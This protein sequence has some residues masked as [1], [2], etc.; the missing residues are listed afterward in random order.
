MRGQFR[1]TLAVPAT[2]ERLAPLARRIIEGQTNHYD[3][4]MAII[5]H[6]ESTCKYTLMEEPTP[7]GTD[8]VEYYLFETRMGAC[9]LAASA[10]A[11]LCRAVDLPARIVVGY[12][13]DQ[14][15]EGGSGFLVRQM[16]AHMWLEVY[17][18]EY[19]WVP[20][21]PAPPSASLEGTAQPNLLQRLQRMILLAARGGLDTFLVVGL[22]V[23]LSILFGRSAASWLRGLA[24]AWQAERLQL[25]AG[26]PAALAIIYRR[27]GRA[28][29]RAGWRRDPAMTPAEY[30][31]WLREQWGPGTPAAERVTRITDHFTRAYYGDEVR[32]GAVREAIGDLSGLRRAAPRRPRSTGA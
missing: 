22:G 12:L 18:Q 27:M 4:V 19:G 16:D 31:Q 1:A 29:A 11:L 25:A 30:E 6:I 23:M 8:A 21:N 24:R 10:A 7:E 28:L 14:P 3:R 2:A 20:F 5:R 13:V 17:F 26:G 32:P 9:D 15:L